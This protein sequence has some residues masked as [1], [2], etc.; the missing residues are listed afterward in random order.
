LI[1]CTFPSVSTGKTTDGGLKMVETG[2][3]DFRPAFIR[4]NCHLTGKQRLR[5]VVERKDTPLLY[6]FKR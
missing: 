2:E 3:T 6:V 5:H 1:D 4:W